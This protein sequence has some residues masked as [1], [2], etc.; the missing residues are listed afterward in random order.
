[1]N[2]IRYTILLLTLSGSYIPS[3]AQD[4]VLSTEPNAYSNAQSFSCAI[5][6]FSGKLFMRWSDEP[7]TGHPIFREASNAITLVTERLKG[8]SSIGER[9]N[10]KVSIQ[11]TFAIEVDGQPLEI[12][13]LDVEEYSHKRY[14]NPPSTNRP[15]NQEEI[16]SIS[17]SVERNLIACMS[18]A[19][20]FVGLDHELQ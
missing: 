4:P 5:S 14:P 20:L 12:K 11:P 15:A 10:V 7:P 1:M 2:K 17:K 19:H 16:A 6:Q 18:K 8:T 9:P 3:Q 13:S